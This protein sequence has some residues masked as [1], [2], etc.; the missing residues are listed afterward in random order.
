MTVSHIAIWTLDI[1]KS[2]SFYCGWFGAKAGSLYANDTTG[3]KSYFLDFGDSCK[4]ELMSTPELV[5]MDPKRVFGLAH[6]AIATGSAEKVDSLTKALRD[7]EFEV[8]SEPRTTGDGYY[9]SVIADPDGNFVE[10]TV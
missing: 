7:Q 9:E 3:F 6:F 5:D 4:L 10:I 8:I 2:K 1:E